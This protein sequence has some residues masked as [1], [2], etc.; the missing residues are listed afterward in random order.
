M[1]F[2]DPPNKETKPLEFKWNKVVKDK[3]SRDTQHMLYLLQLALN[4]V[5]LRTI[6]RNKYFKSIGRTDR[7]IKELDNPQ[8]IAN[9]LDWKNKH[10]NNNIIM[11]REKR[12]VGR[13]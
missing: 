10:N 2:Y 9:F 7:F 13:T 8:V 4:L 5:R 12:A 1:A 3:K 6:E 11:I